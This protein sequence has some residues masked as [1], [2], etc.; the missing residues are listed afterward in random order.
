MIQWVKKFLFDETAFI[1]LMRL[2]FLSA[3][4]MI[5]AYPEAMMELPKWLGVLCLGAGGFIRAGDKNPKG[6]A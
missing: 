4:G 5:I 2:V 1:G 3:G 6:D